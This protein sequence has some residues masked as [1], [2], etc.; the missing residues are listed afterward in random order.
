MLRSALIGL[1]AGSRSITPLAAASIAAA[2]SELPEH[3]RAVRLLGHPLIAAGT[4]ALA[5][6]EMAGDKLASAP[7][8]IDPRGIAA[9]L[10]S[11][12]IAGA[13][14]APRGR[15]AAGALLAAGVATASAY[16]SF[17]A[18]MRAIRDHGRRRTG[19]AEDALIVAG[20]VAVMR[21]GR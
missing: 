5:I 20:T 9:R 4:T 19:F 15:R 21:G 2:R 14:L 10:A 13:A 16:L 7:D 8:R 6:A 12:G 3:D 17:A 18:R 1:V 11:A